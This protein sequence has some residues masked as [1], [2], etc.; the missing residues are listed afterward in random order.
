M[1]ETLTIEKF[2]TMV[3]RY[4][5]PFVGITSQP[6]IFRVLEQTNSSNFL[7]YPTQVVPHYSVWNQP[8]EIA[9]WSSQKV[10]MRFVKRK[11]EE[12]LEMRRNRE[13]SRAERENVGNRKKI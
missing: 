13:V 6:H 8:C 10:M 9:E 5:K 12:T 11:D 4:S 1:N 7:G 2:Q 3:K